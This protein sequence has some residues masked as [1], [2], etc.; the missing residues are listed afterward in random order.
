[1]DQPQPRK[2]IPD[3]VAE[4]LYSKELTEQIL[5]LGKKFNLHIDET[6]SLQKLI[7]ATIAGM[8]PLDE[9]AENV[10]YIV[11]DKTKTTDIVAEVEK[12]IFSKLHESLKQSTT[13]NQQPT[14][15]PAPATVATIET[16]VIAAK[17][18]ETAAPKPVEEIVPAP[19][20]VAVTPAQPQTVVQQPVPEK[21]KEPKPNAPEKYHGPDPYRESFE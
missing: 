7:N 20:P 18:T 12:G 16:P 5:A 9:F 14:T 21:P 4:Y 3:A 2:D 8:F 19:T 13:S 11:S 10:G 17:M 15:T 6:S 1:M